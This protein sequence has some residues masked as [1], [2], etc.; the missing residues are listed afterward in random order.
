MPD[1]TTSAPSPRPR[2]TPDTPP[3][4]VRTPPPVIEIHLTGQDLRD[5]LEADV[6]EG[7]TAP[8]KHLPPI[9]FYDDRGSRLFDEI[10][11][12]PEYYP[13]RAE[14]SILENHAKDIAA[15][16]QATTLIELGA[17]TCDKSRVLLDALLAQGHLERFVPL[18]VSDSTL[19]EAAT[20][21][22]EEYPDVSIH[23]VVADFHRHLHRLPEG[24]TRLFAF[25]GGTIGNLD[26]QERWTFL[27]DLR[28]AMTSRDRLLIGTDLV[29]DRSDL[30]HAY[31]DSAGVTA[32]FNR[33]VLR[34]LNRELG[35]DFDPEEFEHVALWN[36][37][38]SRIEMRLRSAIDQT[39]HIADL[40]LDVSFRSGEE[41]LTEIS[42]KFTPAGVER[43][44]VAVGYAVVEAW[45]SDGEEFQ[46]T[47]ARPLDG[48]VS[49]SGAP[50]PD[51]PGNI[52]PEQGVE[53][54]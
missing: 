34:V 2:S 18:D 27:T 40:D 29:K 50:G 15:R 32:E 12:L 38:D 47:L 35:A 54:A 52:G 37:E 6:H 30:V 44:L 16:A 1:P 31:D 45:R 49:I 10:T 51:W 24:G 23:P 11:R 26:P 36:E 14:R 7:L 17:G 33:N 8:A 22:A 4:P 21:L 43:E 25:L 3:A 42:S 9:Y 20:A 53:G 48:H 28:A 39:A 41:L 13:T 19:A 46:L 5:A